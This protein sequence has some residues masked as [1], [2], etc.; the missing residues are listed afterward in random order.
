MSSAKITR[1][2][3]S[4]AFRLV[5]LWEASLQ[6]TIFLNIRIVPADN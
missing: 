6:P 1:T 5:S 3:F 2:F 4:S